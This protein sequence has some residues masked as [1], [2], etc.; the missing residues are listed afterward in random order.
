MPDRCGAW[1]IAKLHPADVRHRR[2]CT[3]IERFDRVEMKCLVTAAQRTLLIEQLADHFRPDA[4][5]GGA[6]HYPVVTLY[7]DNEERDC[8]WEKVREVPSRRKL[9]LRVY[10]SGDGRVAAASFVEVKHRFDGRGVKR[11]VQFPIAEALRVCD[12]AWP[13]SV[14]LSETDRRLIGEVH[15]LVMRR[16]F[17]PVMVMR[18]NR[19]AFASVDER[20]DVR[21][22]FDSGIYCR[23]NTLVPEP[24]DTRFDSAAALHPDGVG[25]FEVKTAGS[26]PYWLARLIAETGCRLHGHSKYSRALEMQDPR[27]RTRPAPAGMPTSPSSGEISRSPAGRADG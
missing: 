12:G 23:M 22:T 25:V 8:Y 19:S 27:L 13:E 16:G 17:K 11:R 2:G 15:D 9:R 3:V 4:N 7:Y 20:S 21:V 26:I 14:A 24:D 1:W 5:G 18:Y 10:G 6:P